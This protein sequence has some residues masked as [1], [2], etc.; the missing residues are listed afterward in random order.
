MDPR[1]RAAPR[2]GRRSRPRPERFDADGRRLGTAGSGL[3]V[4]VLALSLGAL[5]SAP[6]MHK[7]AFNRQPGAG[8][9]VALA[10]TGP[11]ATI[12]HALLLD[13][14]RQLVQRAIG[15]EG[16]DRID[17]QIALPPAT[18][19]PP[20]TGRT[21]VGAPP[22]RPSG[23]RAAP[24]GRPAKAAFTPKHKLRLWVAGDSLVI[25]PGWSVVR[26]A[27]A[28]AVI[29]PVGGVEGRVA[30]GLGRPDVFN[31]FREIDA[32]MR[33]LKPRAVVLSFGANDDHNY[34]TGVPSGVAIGDFG[35]PSWQR[36]YRRRVA[37]L[38]D[39]VVR[40]GAF[41]V[42]IGLPI[43]RSPSQT[44]GFDTINAIVQEEASKRHGKVAFVDTY[45]MFA[46]DTGGFAEYLP[47]GSGRLVKMRARDGVH[48][49]RAGGELIAREVL[50]RLNEAYDLTSWRRRR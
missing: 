49:E 10:L 28:S 32:R 1:A 47:D 41:L 25:T 12:S 8:R 46:S 40:R 34:M 23:P 26:A 18:T 30:T 37:G 48:F 9:D 29:E 2:A 13:R 45:R 43:T 35:T 19:T 31:W 24:V 39:T 16:A 21:S 7:A 36:E 14:P 17:V 5:L 42:W 20:A 33:T 6:G 27:G 50:K 4:A 38:M 15:R 44:R 11:L 3:V 22:A